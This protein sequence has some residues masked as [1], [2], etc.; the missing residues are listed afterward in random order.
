MGLTTCRA[1]PADLHRLVDELDA[2]A[3]GHLREEVRHVLGVELRAAVAHLSADAPR[4]VRAVDAVEGPVELE[5]V[6]AERV[7]GIAALDERAP[8]A[9]LAEM[10]QPDLLGN[11]PGRVHGLALD[12]EDAGRGGNSFRPRPSGVVWTI[13]VPAASRR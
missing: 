1:R 12:V 13:V 10:L 5:A 11:A 6:L 9:A 2:G 4:K 7:V 3:D 8:V